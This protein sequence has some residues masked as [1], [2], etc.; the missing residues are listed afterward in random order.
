MAPASSQRQ[1]REQTVDKRQTPPTP[2]RQLTPQVVVLRRAASPA[3]H[4]AVVINLQQAGS[5]RASVQ[6]NTAQ[7]TKKQAQ[8]GRLPLVLVQGPV[9]QARTQEDHNPQTHQINISQ[10]RV[11]QNDA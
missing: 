10:H 4:P 2:H 1:H 7:H 11:K 5:H 8:Q 3:Q 9:T 6:H